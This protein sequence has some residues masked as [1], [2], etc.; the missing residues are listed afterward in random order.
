MGL[1]ATARAEITRAAGREA[2]FFRD[3]NS[4]SGYSAVGA[5]MTALGARLQASLYCWHGKRG[6]LRRA[7]FNLAAC[8]VLFAVPSGMAGQAIAGADTYRSQLSDMVA[9]FQI[10]V[11]SLHIFRV[12]LGEFF[13]LF[14][15]ET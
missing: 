10:L 8:L 2:T 5:T 14:L 6:S 11:V 1:A 12:A 4:E 13:L 9:A 7:W 15:M 3:L